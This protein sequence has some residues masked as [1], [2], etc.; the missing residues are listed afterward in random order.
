MCIR[1]ENVSAVVTTKTI[2][3]KDSFYSAPLA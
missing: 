2:L 3:A 1:A